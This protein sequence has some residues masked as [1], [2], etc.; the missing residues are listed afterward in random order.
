MPMLATPAAAWPPPYTHA[1]SYLVTAS[2]VAVMALMAPIRRPP[3]W[4]VN[5]GPI[6]VT[7]PVAVRIRPRRRSEGRAATL[8]AKRRALMARNPTIPSS[9]VGNMVGWELRSVSF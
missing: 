8:D 1:S 9:Q 6:A 2:A 3:V 4:I 7:V 5:D